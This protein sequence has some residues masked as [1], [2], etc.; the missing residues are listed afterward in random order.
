MNTNTSANLQFKLSLD[1]GLFEVW[2]Y[3]QKEY[4]GLDK[5]GIVRLALSSLFKEA[6]RK[7]RLMSIDEIFSELESRK[8]GMTEQ[9]VYDWWNKNKKSIMA[10]NDRHS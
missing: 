8:E 3:L 5:T 2:S 1:S 10:S 6:K 4:K 7:Q 9:E